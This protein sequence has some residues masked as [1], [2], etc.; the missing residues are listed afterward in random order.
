LGS[1]KGA[2]AGSLLFGL[3]VSFS[4][5]YLPERFTFYSI[6]LTFVLLAV[7]LAVRPH[8]LFGRPS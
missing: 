4:P 3:V 5:A 1:L 6:V 8:G 7:V 2:V